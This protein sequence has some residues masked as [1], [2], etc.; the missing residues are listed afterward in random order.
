M[1]ISAEVAFSQ[2]SNALA[3]NGFAITRRDDTMVVMTARNIQR[4][5][6]DTYTDTV[7]PLRP[8]RMVTYTTT[9]QNVPVENI[10]R[11]LRILASRE[12]EMSVYAPGNQLIITDWSS[13]IQR[14]AA[15][16]KLLDK[17]VNPG[18]AKLVAEG[19]KEGEKN[20]LE[21]ESRKEQKHEE[22]TQ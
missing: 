18:I 13:N 1:A 22:K 6:I 16:L 19:R 17:P 14:V 12:G 2:L 4:N 5:L 20:R 9:L 7:P 15:L 21:R 10:N 3:L 11:D 8:E